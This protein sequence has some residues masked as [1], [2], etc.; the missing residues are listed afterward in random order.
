MNKDLVDIM[1]VVLVV[2]V[3]IE[4]VIVVALEALNLVI[5]MVPIMLLAIQELTIIKRHHKCQI[6]MD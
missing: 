6:E 3:A 4:E 5:A 1:V 2:E